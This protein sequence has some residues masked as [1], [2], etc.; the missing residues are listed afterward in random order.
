LS[1]PP[2]I[3]ATEVY[4][5]TVD[6]SALSPADGSSPKSGLDRLVAPS[7]EVTEL[8][9]ATAKWGT[10]EV[11][12]ASVFVDVRGT[13]GACLKTDPTGPWKIIRPAPAINNNDTTEQCLS[14]ADSTGLFF[15]V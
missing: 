2:R 15:I 3:P 1:I 9:F 14:R 4:F 6:E 11:L 10:A 7:V 12:A 13:V 8:E 5:E